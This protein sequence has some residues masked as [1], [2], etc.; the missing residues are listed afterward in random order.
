[1][2]TPAR[3]LELVSLYFLRLQ[4]YL[5]ETPIPSLVAVI[6]ALA[7]T[8]RLR[9]MDRVLLAG[10]ALLV[11]SYFA[12]WH[13]GFYLGPRFFVCLLPALALW[14]ARVFPEWRARWGRDA[15]YRVVV[16]ASVVSALIA[17]FISI[18]VR[19]NQYRGGLKT[20]R[21][22]L[23]GA[24]RDAGVRNALVF[25]RES[26]GAQLMVRL[27]AVG[28]SHSDA[29]ALYRSVD[30]CALERGLDSLERTGG[31]DAAARA[32]L[33]PLMADSARVVR[34]PF[35]ADSSER[36]LPG[37][38]YGARC[39]RR[40]AGR[41]RGVHRIICRSSSPMAITSSMRGICTRAIRC[42]SHVIRRAPCISYGRRPT[43]KA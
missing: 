3:G 20:M 28:I 17:V 4:S 16:V 33:F 30:A 12:Y 27:W 24:A 25:V 29:Q 5:F 23:E 6:V 9:L 11:V 2:H 32:V 43:A 19:A 42:C 14:S 1:M 26:W 10:S 13:D 36:V 22:D 18:P 21:W 31:R 35:S 15:S 37:S 39:V 40:L 7:L 41:S 8:K 38:Q 34:S